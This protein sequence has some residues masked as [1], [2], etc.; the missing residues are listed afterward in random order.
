MCAIK[1]GS[2]GP[3][4]LS[5]YKDGLPIINQERV[6][7]TRQSDTLSTLTLRNLRPEDFGNYTCVATNAQG[8]DQYSTTLIIPGE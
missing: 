8:T 1:S 4:D 3:H 6:T 2:H 7:V 5:W